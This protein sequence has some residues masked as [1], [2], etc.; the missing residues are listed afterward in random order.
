MLPIKEQDA[1]AV[2]QPA[3]WYWGG[4]GGSKMY[5][6]QKR[7]TTCARASERLRDISFQVSKYFVTS[8]YTINIVPLYYLWYGAINKQQNIHR[9]LTLRKSMRA[10]GASE[11]G[12][13][14]HFDTQKL[15]FLSIF[16]WYFRY[17][18]GT[19]DMIVRFIHVPTNNFQMY[20]QNS[21]KHHCC[22][23]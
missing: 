5:R 15:L 10:S 17:F 21:E 9:T 12:K 4:G 23:Q 1:P 13:F 14:S 3:F 20:R 22:P 16:C 11:L 19:N 18:V 8:A 7:F 2:A 6:Q